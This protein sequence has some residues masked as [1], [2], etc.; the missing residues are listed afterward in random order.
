MG[1]PATG[2]HGRDIQKHGRPLSLGLA[3]RE[4]LHVIVRKVG[5][6]EVSE[7]R[8]LAMHATAG[9]AKVG[10]VREKPGPRHEFR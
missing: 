8:A 2:I 7:H 3:V 6:V 5:E 4:A 1:G 9:T 10:V